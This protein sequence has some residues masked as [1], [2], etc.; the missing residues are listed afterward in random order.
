MTRNK[1]TETKNYPN[2]NDAELSWLQQAAVLRPDA[3]VSDL[4]DS[5]LTIFPDR[6]THDGLTMQQ[7]RKKLT[8]RVNDILYRKDRGYTEKV[9]QKRNDF[10]E[11]FASVFAV[12]S[13]LSQL[14]FYEQIFTNPKSKPSDKFKA[15]NDAE[16]LKAQLFPPPTAQQQVEMDRQR[17]IL[18]EEAAKIRKDLWRLLI[19]KR[20]D[21]IYDQLPESLENKIDLRDFNAWEQML[22]VLEDQGLSDLKKQTHMKHS[23][24]DCDLLSDA[25]LLEID[26]KLSNGGLQKM[27][28]EDLDNLISSYLDPEKKAAID[29]LKR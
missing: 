12:L 25:A 7:I 19:Q 10:Q 5:F 8:S 20:F 26:S 27:S 22:D 15:I 13:A 11:V 14:N 9:Q 2:L 17:R 6:A 28:I 4:I 21:S 24:R 29:R 18:T 16:K 3:N 1:L 23:R